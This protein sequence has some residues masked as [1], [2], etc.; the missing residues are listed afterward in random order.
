MMKQECEWMKSQ[1]LPVTMDNEETD[2]SHNPATS[3]FL[4]VTQQKQDLV[5]FHDDPVLKS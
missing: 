3:L 4:K 2:E 1:H 5:S